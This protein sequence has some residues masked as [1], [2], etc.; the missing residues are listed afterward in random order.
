M[1]ANKK[2]RGLRNNEEG[3]TF[4]IPMTLAIVIGV[5]LMIAGS[6]VVGTMVSE[7]EDSFGTITSR[8]ENENRTVNLMGNITAGFSN[9]VDIEFVVIT[10]TALSMAVLAIM[11]IASRRA[12]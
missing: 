12:F 6:Y 5:C 1:K 2:F 4:I 8:S 3:F 11:A 10:I 7:L 9:V